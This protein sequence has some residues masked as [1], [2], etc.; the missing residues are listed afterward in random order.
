MGVM[1]TLK[2]VR[3]AQQAKNQMSE[4]E[5]AGRSKS[6]LTALLLN[7]LS[8]IVEISFDDELFTNIDA[9]RLESEVIEA[10]EDAKKQLEKEMA[11][12]MDMDSLRDLLSQ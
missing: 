8:E 6:G 1:D 4:I 12:N 9:S 2:M 11:K 3:K 7:G 10:F 5:V